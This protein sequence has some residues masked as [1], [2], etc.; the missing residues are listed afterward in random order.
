[1]T[2]RDREAMRGSV[3]FYWGRKVMRGSITFRGRSFLV[4]PA[5]LA[6]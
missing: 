1:M 3:T 5:S 6:F 4:F 2:S